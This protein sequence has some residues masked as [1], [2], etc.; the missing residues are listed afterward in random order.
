MDTLP[1]DTV[2]TIVRGVLDLGPDEP[3][4]EISQATHEQWT[5]IKHVQIIISLE[6]AFDVTFSHEE[7]ASV[8]SV[9]RLRE[10]LAEKGV[11]G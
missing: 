1:L 4:G 10:V 11:A 2:D 7:M 8:D 6:D 3:P 5:S 9:G